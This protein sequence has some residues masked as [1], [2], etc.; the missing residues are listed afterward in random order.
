MK[1]YKVLIDQQEANQKVFKNVNHSMEKASRG[2]FARW[3]VLQTK[4]V[5]AELL[6]PKTCYNL[7]VDTWPNWLCKSSNDIFALFTS[8]KELQRV[9]GTLIEE[10]VNEW[11]ARSRT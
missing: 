10:F 11:L 4:G 6:Q 2:N 7:C 3:Q 9:T 8:K 5:P 1:C